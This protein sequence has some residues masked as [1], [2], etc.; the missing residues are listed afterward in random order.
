MIATFYHIFSSDKNECNLFCTWPD[1][2]ICWRN[3]SNQSVILTNMLMQ[4][5]LYSMDKNCRYANIALFLRR[6]FFKYSKFKIFEKGNNAKF[7]LYCLY[8]YRL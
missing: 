1:T 3:V 2:Y 5:P 7:L 8:L 6:I 4:Q